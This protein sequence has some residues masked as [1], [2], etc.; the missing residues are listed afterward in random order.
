MFCVNLRRLECEPFFGG[1]VFV[2]DLTRASDLE[3]A[4]PFIVKKLLNL[5]MLIQHTVDRADGCF[6]ADAESLRQVFIFC[7]VMKGLQR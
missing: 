4:E 5:R 6:N 2:F 1:V 3:E 7:A